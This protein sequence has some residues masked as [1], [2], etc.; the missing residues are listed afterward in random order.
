M[1]A[2][3]TCYTFKSTVDDNFWICVCTKNVIMTS[4]VVLTVAEAQFDGHEIWTIRWQKDHQR[5]NVSELILNL[6]N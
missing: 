1:N 2:L 5:A 6:M 3:I 4:Q